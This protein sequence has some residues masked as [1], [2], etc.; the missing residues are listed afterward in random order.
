M[1]ICPR[2][3]RVSRSARRG[4]HLRT[5]AM[6]PMSS[7]LIQHRA[8]KVAC[9]NHQSPAVPTKRTRRTPPR[10]SRLRRTRTVQPVPL[11]WISYSSFLHPAGS[12]S[13]GIAHG[14]PSA[15]RHTDDVTAD[16]SIIECLVVSY[17][18][19]T[20]V[21]ERERDPGDEGIEQAGQR[22]PHRRH[23]PS[24]RLACLVQGPNSP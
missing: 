16:N 6:T 9:C 2:R 8:R 19:G 24:A 11:S 21:V 15:P 1:R 3:S 20:R 17:P 7:P 22:R 10:V 13:P 4:S 18:K 14:G 5:A 12:S 23:A